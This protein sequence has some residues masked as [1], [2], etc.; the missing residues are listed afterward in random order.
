M[1]THQHGRFSLY[2]EL[3]VTMA[4]SASNNPKPIWQGPR[5][6]VP[7]FRTVLDRSSYVTFPEFVFGVKGPRRHRMGKGQSQAGSSPERKN[8]RKRRKSA[9]RRDEIRDSHEFLL[10]SP[11]FL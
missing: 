11:G 2:H 9:A 1:D 3:L 5:V 4:F 6:Q 10:F 8:K 7:P